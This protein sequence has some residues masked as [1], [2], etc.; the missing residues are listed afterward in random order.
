MARGESRRGEDYGRGESTE[1]GPKTLT[2]E[3][4]VE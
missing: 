1:E 3:L 2:W 4:R